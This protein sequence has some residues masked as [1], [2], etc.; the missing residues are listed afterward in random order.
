MKDFS[1]IRCLVEAFGNLATTQAEERE[2][3]D[4]YIDGGGYSWGYHGQAYFEAI[5][6]AAEELST[7]LDEYIDDRIANE[8]VQNAL[9]R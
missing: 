2:A 6:K 1:K 4:R 3:R 8:R 9:R 5:D 7:R